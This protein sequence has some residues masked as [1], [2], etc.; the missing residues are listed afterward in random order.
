ML[1]EAR[2]KGELLVVDGGRSLS[3]RGM[4]KDQAE[5]EQRRVKAELVARSFAA[6]GIDAMAV[7]GADWTL[8]REFVVD[9][10]ARER[11]PVLAAN[12]VCDGAAPFPGGKVSTIGGLRVGVVAVTEGPV[13]GCEVTEPRAAIRAAV[14][15]L[16]PVDVRIA[17]VP[18]DSDRA[19]AAFAAPEGGDAPLP[20]DVA[21][22]ARG[23]FPDSG[24][25][26]RQE[27]WWVPGGQQ[28]KK[29]GF[30]ELTTVPGASG[31]RV[32]GGTAAQSRVESLRARLESAERRLAEATDAPSRERLARQAETYRSQVAALEAAAAAPSDARPAHAIDIQTVDLDEE[33]AD[34][35]LSLR[36]VSEAKAAVTALAGADPRVFV[37]RA[38]TDASSPFAGG[39]ACVRCHGQQHA[40]WSTTGH[41]RAWT[42]L[43]AVDRALD[44]ECWSCHVTGAN[45]PGGPAAP[46]ATVGFRD[47]Q[48]E[49]CHGPSRAHAAAP[50]AAASPVPRPGAETCVG[51]HDGE[52][53]QGRFDAGTYLPKVVHRAVGAPPEGAS[54]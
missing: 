27:T 16:G 11:L 1:D 47:V 50:E 25:D 5:L 9:L 54:P 42:G 29:I 37:A 49:A 6:A 31:W 48:C 46:T 33:V 53:D 12:L 21:I 38:V 34:H 4:P 24:A 52:Q 45:A 41:A 13:E 10:A 28:G 32:K 15:A 20:I 18:V 35:P 22:D 36:L 44:A 2:R 8:G 23:R 3:P 43:V 40:Q 19:F 14:A 26:L 51:C 17:L 30:L 7:A 39:E